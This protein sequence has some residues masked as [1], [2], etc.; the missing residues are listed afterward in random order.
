[1]PLWVIQVTGK[2]DWHW[3]FLAHFP[4]FSEVFRAFKRECFSFSLSPIMVLIDFKALSLWEQLK[5]ISKQTKG[6]LS[7]F[8]FMKN[9][10]QLNQ[11]FWKEDPEDILES[12]TPSAPIFG[13]QATQ[14]SAYSIL[15]KEE[16]MSMNHA[17]TLT[18]E[19]DFSLNQWRQR[20]YAVT[21]IRDCHVFILIQIW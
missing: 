4:Y 21:E 14:W 15:A 11:E 7:Y 18:E 9:N 2:T 3:T 10:V 19:L 5:K 1:M 12:A 16:R 17:E 13:L 8:E 20:S 6:C